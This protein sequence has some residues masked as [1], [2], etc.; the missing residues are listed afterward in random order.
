MVYAKSRGR[1]KNTIPLFLLPVNRMYLARDE[2]TNSVTGLPFARTLFLCC[3]FSVSLYPH[4]PLPPLSL[5]LV[6]F[7]TKRSHKM[8][9]EGVVNIMEKAVG[10]VCGLYNDG[11]ALQFAFCCA[12]IWSVVPFPIILHFSLFLHVCVCPGLRG[13]C[14]CVCIQHIVTSHTLLLLW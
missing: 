4:V 2:G 10:D 9:R 11:A 12:K 8:T 6:S 1:Y 13:G 5:P 3:S 7:Y 14:E